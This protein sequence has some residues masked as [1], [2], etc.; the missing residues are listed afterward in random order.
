[1]H[2]RLILES[3][4]RMKNETRASDSRGATLHRPTSFLQPGFR[5][6]FCVI[7]TIISSKTGILEESQHPLQVLV[8][9]SLLVAGF[10]TR[11]VATRGSLLAQSLCY[12][13]KKGFPS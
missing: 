3:H 11:W 12:I 2:P 13:C 9:K 10:D 7:C 5:P 6:L 1:M 4:S 8:A